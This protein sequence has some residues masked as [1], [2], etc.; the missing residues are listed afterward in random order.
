M[1]DPISC[2]AFKIIVLKKRL[3]VCPSVR[4][5]VCHAMPGEWPELDYMSFARLFSNMEVESC[6]SSCFKRHD[7]LWYS[8]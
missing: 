8:T 5:S 7:Q 1:Y 3:S 2:I 6:K 4:L